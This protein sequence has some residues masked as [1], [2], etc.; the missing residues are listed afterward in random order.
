MGDLGQSLDGRILVA[1]LVP[2]RPGQPVVGRRAAR[3][4]LLQRVAR[5]ERL[6]LL[7]EVVPIP[8]E[9]NDTFAGYYRY[10]RTGKF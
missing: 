10:G 2:G 4:P 1:R 5:S 7:G 6:R 3:E 8:T 9:V